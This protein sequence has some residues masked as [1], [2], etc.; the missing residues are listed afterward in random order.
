MKRK[1]RFEYAKNKMSFSENV[2]NLRCTVT[3][4]SSRISTLQNWRISC[5]WFVFL[6]RLWNTQKNQ[7]RIVQPILP[8]NWIG[9][10]SERRSALGNELFRV[11]EIFHIKH[12]PIKVVYLPDKH[13]RHY[14]LIWLNLPL[15][16]KIRNT[17]SNIL[18]F[19]TDPKLYYS[20]YSFS[21]P[22]WLS[23]HF[24]PGSDE[25]V[26]NLFEYHS[27]EN[28]DYLWFS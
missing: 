27:F 18:L 14:Y 8:L 5:Y 16:K 17:V 1:Q 10:P 23:L 25:S 6:L 26:R 4:F 13:W 15:V 19:Q 21:P 28:N 2:I 11:N 24:S 20:L 22:Y 9:N 3:P 7:I 12:K